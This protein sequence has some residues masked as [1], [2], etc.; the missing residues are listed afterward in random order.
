M[1][2]VYKPSVQIDAFSVTPVPLYTRKTEHRKAIGVQ[3]F[4]RSFFGQRDTGVQVYKLSGSRR[5]LYARRVL[6]TRP[7][8]DVHSVH[9]VH[10]YTCTHRER[11]RVPVGWRPFL[12][13]LVASRARVA[14]PDFPYMSEDSETRLRLSWRSADAQNFRSL[15]K[16]VANV[17]RINADPTRRSRDDA[18]RWR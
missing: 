18:K 11:G 5:E 9:S 15:K 6:R 8:Q 10:L 7:E 3:Q 14:R 12:S 2:G 4:S 17:R 13:C 1:S 16:T